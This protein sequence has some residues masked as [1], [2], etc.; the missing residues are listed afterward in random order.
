M[1]VVLRLHWATGQNAVE[2]AHLAALLAWID[3]P[4]G[5][6]GAEAAAEAEDPEV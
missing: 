1:T 6:S 3:P 4:P 2:D 5:R